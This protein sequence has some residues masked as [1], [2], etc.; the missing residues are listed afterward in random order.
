MAP[1]FKPRPSLD[2]PEA[3]RP[4]GL[5]RETVNEIK[6][7]ILG[8]EQPVGFKNPPV[9]TRFKKGQS[10]N[11]KGRPK[12]TPPPPPPETPN[13][14]VEQA[15]LAETERIVQIRENGETREMKA[16]EVV[17]RAHFKAAVDGSPHAQRFY[18][19]NHYRAKQAEETAIQEDHA[20][21]RGYVSRR[22]QE[23]ADAERNGTEPPA[24]L[25]HPDDVVFEPGKP[26]YF[27]GP[28]NEEEQ[29]R[30][31][32]QLALRDLLLMQAGYERRLFFDPRA[33]D[34]FNTPYHLARRLNE[35]F[36]PRHQLDVHKIEDIVRR[37]FCTSKRALLPR[38]RRAWREFGIPRRRGAVLPPLAE[39][40]TWAETLLDFLRF[41]RES[42]RQRYMD[43]LRMWLREDQPP[44]S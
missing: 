16:F 38:L 22:W 23:I 44:K 26:V 39:W 3:A 36:P 34:F 11:P 10:G 24:R 31:E 2:Q 8:M 28:A 17:Q 6:T 19:A 35:G 37:Y 21:W 30:F 29:W 25:P 27:I 20:F 43:R 33:D 13:L 41:D 32:K 14:P 42:T 12:R 9:R 5:T 40:D 18:M 1:V 7:K 15:I 4:K